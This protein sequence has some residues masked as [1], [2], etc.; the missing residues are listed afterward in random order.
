M[1][2]FLTY[3]AHSRLYNPAFS[4]FRLWL[5]IVFI[6]IKPSFSQLF[7]DGT[8]DNLHEWECAVQNRNASSP[9][10]KKGDKDDVVLPHAMVKEDTYS[11]ERSSS[12]PDLLMELSKMT[13][14]IFEQKDKLG[15]LGGRPMYPQ[16][17]F[18]HGYNLVASHGVTM[19]RLSLHQSVPEAIQLV[20]H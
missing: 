10:D 15:H 5:A 2:V 1:V 8:A 7:V 17:V 4:L 14:E 13:N 20:H 16:R 11:H 9:S 3:L 6:T 12:R 19:A 18:C